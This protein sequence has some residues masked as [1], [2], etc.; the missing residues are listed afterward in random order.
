M[1]HFAKIG[2]NNIVEDVLV[3]DNAELQGL[4]FPESEPLGV[5]F[6]KNLF[7]EDTKWL[8]TSYNAKF[9]KNYACIG[10]EY[11]PV[12]DAFL[13]IKPYT[14]WVLNEQTF[15]WVAPVPYPSDGKKYIWDEATISWKEAT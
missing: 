3:L 8:Q 1:A 15:N 10:G 7:G 6:F 4:D 9:R 14:S 12:R 11:D 2:I 13:P 5:A